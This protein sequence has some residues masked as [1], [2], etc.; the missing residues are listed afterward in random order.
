M[1]NYVLGFMFSLDGHQ[2]VLIQKTKPA[3]QKG[4]LN[5][6]GGKIE[7]NETPLE[8]MQRE[9]LEETGV[10]YPFWEERLQM[11]GEGWHCHVFSAFSNRV[12]KCST[13]TEEPVRVIPTQMIPSSVISNLKWLIPF[14]LEV[15]VSINSG[16]VINY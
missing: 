2:V 15:P 1:K 7:D 13:T 5:G 4:L 10:D 9:F 16:L 12:S 11:H 6:V 3:W 8:A 14:L